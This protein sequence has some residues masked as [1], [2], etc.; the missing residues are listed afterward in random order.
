MLDLERVW[1]RVSQA[2]ALR[3]RNISDFIYQGLVLNLSLTT[4]AVASNQTQNFPSGAIILG[5][6]AAAQVASQAATQTYRPGLDLFSVAIDYQ[7][8]GRSIVGTAQGIGSA[9]FGPY[10][11]QFPRKE[12][13]VPTNATLVYSVTNLT[14]ST[15]TVSFVHHCLVPNATA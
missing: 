14:T 12:I 3:G 13:L 10:G 7:T 6:G 2:P 1:Q 4:G 15:I 5:V 8:G 9:V 11:D